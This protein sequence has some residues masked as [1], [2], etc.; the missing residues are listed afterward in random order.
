M[1][2]ILHL[3]QSTLDSHKIVA[4]LVWE[5][6][7]RIPQ[8]QVVALMPIHNNRII[9]ICIAM[10]A[11]II[12]IIACRG[13]QENI[14]NID[15]LEFVPK[16]QVQWGSIKGEVGESN[17]QLLDVV[18]Q[19]REKVWKRRSFQ[20]W[21]TKHYIVLAS[22][23]SYLLNEEKRSRPNHKKVKKRFWHKETDFI[24]QHSFDLYRCLCWLS[25][26][27]CCRQ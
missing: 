10:I 2:R 19:R 4:E 25:E 7:L 27:E 13:L 24:K 15:F 8:Y 22:I 12:K 23:E 6:S 17:E 11:A 16:E 26:N 9:A 3:L 18:F 21:F 14:F 1:K 20:V 5:I